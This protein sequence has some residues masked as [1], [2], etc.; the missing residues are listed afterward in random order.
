M[1]SCIDGFPK[2]SLAPV[3]FVPLSDLISLIWPFLP[4]NRLNAAEKESVSKLCAIFMIS[5]DLKG[6]RSGVRRS[7]WRTAI[8]CSQTGPWRRR[9]STHLESTLPS[10]V[11]AF[12]I[13]KL[14]ARQT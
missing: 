3:K 9:Q 12:M 11:L 10:T 8:F 13:K 5:T 4:I 7:T 2:F 6:D 1:V 14:L